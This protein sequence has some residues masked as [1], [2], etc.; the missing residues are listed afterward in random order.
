MQLLT[1][2]TVYTSRAYFQISISQSGPTSM[3]K[4]RLTTQSHSYSDISR[5]FAS[6]HN[7]RMHKRPCP[8]TRRTSKYWL[9]NPKNHT[10]RSYNFSMQTQTIVEPQINIIDHDL[11]FRYNFAKTSNEEFLRQL[12]S[13]VAI[14]DIEVWDLQLGPTRTLQR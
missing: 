5:G 13:V 12:R 1:R 14:L 6:L 4:E 7:R 11:R 10:Q 3:S 2:D 8:N 9:V